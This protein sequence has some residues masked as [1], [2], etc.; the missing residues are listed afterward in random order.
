MTR[1]IL[2]V[3]LFAFC[4]GTI[5]FAQPSA[6]IST[7]RPAIVN[8]SVKGLLTNRDTTLSFLNLPVVQHLAEEK[9]LTSMSIDEQASSLPAASFSIQFTF[10][11]MKEF[12]TWYN[13]PSTRK[14][15]AE[16]KLATRLGGYASSLSMNRSPFE[17]PP[18]EH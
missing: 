14:L 1:R 11:D 10:K 2:L 13:S 8:Y 9:Q 7:E 12:S 17:M 5:A 15:F 3:G 6:S 18:E 16:L 4:F